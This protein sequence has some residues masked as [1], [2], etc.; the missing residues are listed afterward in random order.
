MAILY[1]RSTDGSDVDSGAT[2][3]L[4]KAT[5]AGA[6]TAAVAGDTIYVSQVHAETQATAMTLTSPGTA[7]SP[8]FVIC[9]NDAA[10][11]PTAVA[12]TA[13][14]T[15]TGNSSITYAGF[16]HVYGVT[17]NCG[18][19]AGGASI[20]FTS[21]APWCWVF[22]ACALKM[23]NSAAASRFTA[24][25]SSTASDDQYLHLH[26]TS[27]Q[28]AGAAQGIIVRCPFEWTG[29]SLTLG[30]LPT[31]LFLTPSAGNCGPAIITG[32][33]LSQLNAGES[34][35]DVASGNF[36]R[37]TFVNCK[38]GSSVAVT[39]GTNPG[40]GATQVQLINCDSADTN[41]RYHYHCYQGDITQETVI[42]RTG[43][44]TDGTTPLSFKAVSS[45]NPRFFSALKSEWVYY[46]LNTTGAVTV[47]IETVTDNV[48]L[49]DAEAWIEVQY[50][51]TAGVPWGLFANDRAAD[52]LATPANQTTSSETWTT[53]GLATPVKQVLSKAVTVEEK[54]LIRARLILA[55][56]STTVYF[57]PEILTGASRSY[58]TSGGYANEAVAAGGMK[59][60]PGM[61]G[62]I[63]G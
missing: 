38:L 6:F 7:A 48:T 26:N 11:P 47:A 54:G 17:F 27:V 61:V 56:A 50:L 16:A 39:T 23:I 33:D 5:L 36:G 41:Y 13:T 51:G 32:V 25:V 60:H 30:T 62:G 31:T 43:G 52:I 9:A 45:A 15:T 59:V 53:T 24:G 57:C 22:D 37:Y 3:A 34:L 4:A 1:V 28:F 12:T 29:G 19:G 46:W 40:P 8:V 14:I 35:V 44:A 58:M 42:V 2:W 10:E 18:T 63:A 55:K 49:T 21:A 20:N